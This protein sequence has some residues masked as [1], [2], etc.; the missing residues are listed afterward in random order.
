MHLCIPFAAFEVHTVYVASVLRLFP[1]V[2]IGLVIMDFVVEL[3]S[4]NGDHVLSRIVLEGTCQEGLRE[5][6]P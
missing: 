4:I 1:D 3:D 2:L 5:E 6:E